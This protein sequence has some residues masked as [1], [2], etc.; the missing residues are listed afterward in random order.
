VDYVALM[1][2]LDEGG[3]GGVVIL[4][5]NSEDDLVESLERVRP[6]L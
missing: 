4:E 2:R 3:Y 1:N 5:V 6:W